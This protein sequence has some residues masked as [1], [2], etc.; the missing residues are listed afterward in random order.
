MAGQIGDPEQRPTASEAIAMVEALIPDIRPYQGM[1]VEAIK[2]PYDVLGWNVWLLLDGDREL[3]GGKALSASLQDWRDSKTG[4]LK[5][6]VEA[7]A[8]KLARRR[9]VRNSEGSAP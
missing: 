8:G 6:M 5:A 2:P 9:A 1:G 3:V 4:D 7:A